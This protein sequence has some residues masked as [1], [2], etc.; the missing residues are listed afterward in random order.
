MKE[1]HKEYLAKHGVLIPNKQNYDSTAKSIWLAVLYHFKEQPVHKDYIS[2]VCQRDK[3]NLGRD[4]Q[5]RH[6]KRDGWSLSN[7]GK[8]NHTLIPYEPSLEFINDKARR[9]SQLNAR[10]F[11]ELKTAYGNRCATCGASKRKPDNRYGRDK[12][13]LQQGHRDPEKPSSDKNN[14]IPQCQFCN[15]AYKGDFT[16]DDKGRVSA[17]ADIAPVKRASDK[18]KYKIFS[19]LQDFFRA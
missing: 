7:D 8:G 6:L 9:D 4:Q 15:R 17:V 13:A 19:W 18:V 2:D 12:V 1:I 16:F 5:V 3:P 10:S 14:I 11:K